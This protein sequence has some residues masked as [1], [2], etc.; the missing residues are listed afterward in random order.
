MARA[1][2]PELGR[3]VTHRGLVRR[4]SADQ[5]DGP[6]RGQRRVAGC[7][8]VYLGHSFDMRVRAG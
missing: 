5:W 4:T 3:T 1:R 7:E 2:P 6:L 8:V